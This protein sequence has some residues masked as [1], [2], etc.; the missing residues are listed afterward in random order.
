MIG[1]NGFLSDNRYSL[2]K[3]PP[4]LHVVDT[5]FSELILNHARPNE[6]R[7]A[8]NVGDADKLGEVLTREAGKVEE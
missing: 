6:V 5:S 1:G 2:L 3:G 8:T 4:D 7:F